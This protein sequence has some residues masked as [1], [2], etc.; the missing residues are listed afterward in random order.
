MQV[1]LNKSRVLFFHSFKTRKGPHQITDDAQNLKSD[2]HH[3]CLLDDLKKK[4]QICKNMQALTI[5][6]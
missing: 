3:P 5:M 2:L 1:K 6:A 4:D